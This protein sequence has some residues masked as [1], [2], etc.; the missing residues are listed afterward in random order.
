MTYGN[1]FIIA[2]PGKWVDYPFKRGIDPTVSTEIKNL[3]QDMGLD[4]LP[5]TDRDIN[6]LGRCAEDNAMLSFIPNDRLKYFDQNKA[7]DQ[8]KE[9]IKKY[10]LT[11]K[12]VKIF[13]KA[14][15]MSEVQQEKFL[16]AFRVPELNFV[17][18]PPEKIAEIYLTDN[19]M[20]SHTLGNSCMRK[21]YRAKKSFFKVYEKKAKGI[22]VAKEG[23][24]VLGRALLWDVSIGGKRKI[25][26]DRVYSGTFAYESSFREYAVKN[27]WYS[28]AHQDF[29]TQMD[30][31]TPQRTVEEIS[32]ELRIKKYSYDHLP[33]CDT[34][35]YMNEEQTRLTNDLNHA[36]KVWNQRYYFML[37]GLHGTWETKTN[38]YYTGRQYAVPQEEPVPVHDDEDYVWSDWCQEDILEGEAVLTYNND[39]I[40]YEDSVTLYPGG[41]TA[42]SEDEDVCYSD[43]ENIYMFR[44]DAAY[45]EDLDDYVYCE[46]ATY[47]DITGCD[48]LSE[49]AVELPDGSYTHA[50][51][52]VYD[53]IDNVNIRRDE[54]ITLA[55][56]RRTH[57]DNAEL[58]NEQYQLIQT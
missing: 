17:V 11:G 22:V 16:A 38:S 55:D 4:F 10:T 24:K 48:I 57:E 2:S 15:Y 33:F 40:Y 45:I 18:E 41:Q 21:A 32:I 42:H 6:Y 26:M 52:T 8:Q 51:N 9:L 49:D 30:M 7:L 36:R 46:N 28:K 5:R 56:G 3:L 58:V 29:E 34:F 47:D 20:N 50:D 35:I 14:Y 19:Y 44:D 27:G 53:E 31:Y 25:L 54:V 1:E 43:H 37:Q 23:E 39:W 13:K 12:P